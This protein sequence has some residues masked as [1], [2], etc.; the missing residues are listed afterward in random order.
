MSMIIEH[1]I[2][3]DLT[4]PGT[5]PR[6]QVK[7]G[8]YSSRRVTL[9]L[10]AGTAAWP[11]PED[12]VAMIRYHVHDLDG[13]ED[14]VGIY[15]T[16]PDGTTAWSISENTVSFI[17]V[18]DMTARHSIVAA[19]V[20]LLQETSIL[21]T[22]N[23][24]FYVNRAPVAETEA[25]VQNYYNVMSLKEIYAQIEGLSTRLE[26]QASAVEQRMTTLETDL[27]GLDLEWRMLDQRV[28]DL[29][30]RVEGLLK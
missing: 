15:D 17:P 10:Y 3:I 8:D 11:V 6:I 16:L 26:E 4:N 9:Q 2:T 30:I 22:F 12:A 25:N 7:Q 13:G 28:D 5:T 1:T 18:E 27:S 24:E 21:S 29:E 23:I 14:A 19:D 20:V